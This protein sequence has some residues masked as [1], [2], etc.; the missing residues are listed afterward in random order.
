M[1]RLVKLNIST[2]FSLIAAFSLVYYVLVSDNF[3]HISI[4]SIIS[5]SH[6]LGEADHI[7]VLGLLPIYIALMIFGAGMAGV[8]L[9]S[10]IQQLLIRSLNKR[11]RSEKNLLGNS[12]IYLCDTSHKVCKH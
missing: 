8:Y 5:S 7:L 1:K 9:G 10:A 6:Y 4:A 12:P 11:L 3:L 2:V